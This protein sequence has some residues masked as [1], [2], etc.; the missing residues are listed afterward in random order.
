MLFK[1]V[2]DLWEKDNSQTKTIS[3]FRGKIKKYLKNNMNM[4]IDEALDE[5]KL[6][7]FIFADDKQSARGKYSA[8]YNIYKYTN[9]KIMLITI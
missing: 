9:E 3:Q 8:L 5:N 2:V 7:D 6:F 1:E 4:T